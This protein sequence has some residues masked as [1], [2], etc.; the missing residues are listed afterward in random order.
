MQEIIKQL[1]LSLF[2]NPTLATIFISITGN[3]EMKIVAS[4]GFE[5]SESA[6]CFIISCI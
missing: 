3:I 4:V 6:N 1:A 5:K 2:S